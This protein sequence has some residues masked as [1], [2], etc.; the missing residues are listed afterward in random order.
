[1]VLP[2]S[3]ELLMAPTMSP[4]ITDLRDNLVG[5]MPI[6]RAAD[7]AKLAG[8][9]ITTVLIQYLTWQARLI[10]PR[11]RS[12]VIWPEVLTSPHYAVHQA[13]VERLKA[14][15]ETG[16]DVNAALSSQ[17]RT[18]VYA[19][20]LPK[21]TVAMTQEEWVKKAWKGKDRMRVLVDAHHLHLGPRNSDGTVGRTG[22]LLFAG[23]TPDQAF[24]LTIGDHDSFDD[25]RITK[26]MHDKLEAEVMASG[27]GVY[28]PPGGGV[29]LGGTKIED[30]LRAI[31]IVKTLE[32]ID[33]KLDEQNAAGY[34]IR[35]DWDDILIA[36]P[37]GNEIQRIKGKL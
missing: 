1:M 26:M 33:Q 30:T 3:K 20:D 28:M 9:Y 2:T 10:R 25:G 13:D 11:P 7:Q 5:R 23:I 14:E 35:I 16:I 4:R 6:R 29:T 24:F 34:A 17:V 18:N 8:E 36:D 21:K 15:F 27:G 37:Q 19:G 12:V 32:R 31:N 22:P